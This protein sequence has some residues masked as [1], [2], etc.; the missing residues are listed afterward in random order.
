MARKRFLI[1]G[2]GAAG[3]AAAER[4]RY[5]DPSASI[6]LYTDDPSP[7][8]YRAAL[9]NFLLGELREEQ[10]WAV[11][12]SFYDELSIQRALVRV[13]KVETDKK[14]L[15]L[16]QGGRPI[17]YDALVLACGARARPPT[18]DGSMLPGVMVM[19]TLSDVHRVFDLIKL[20]GLRSAVICGGGPLA[21][22]WAHGLTHRGIKV[23]MVVRDRKFLP[24]A[25]DNVSSDL[26]LARLRQGGVEV[27]MGDEVVQAVPGPQGRV[28]GV[29]LKSG[30]RVGCELVGVAFGVICNSE[31]LQGSPIALSKQGGIV[32]D[33]R[34]SAEQRDAIA[35]IA[36][37]GAGGPMAA[38]SGLVGKFLGVEAAPIDFKRNG[39]SWSVT[40]S[41][42]IRLAG[43]G[44]TG[45]NPDAAPM[46]LTNTG[47]PAA[48]TF[49]LAR[50]M[51]SRVA[52]LGVS[53]SDST[54]RN[55]A[56]YAPFSWANA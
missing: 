7:G 8:Y 16:A 39:N 37:G 31:F 11:P 28:A 51:D 10:V 15:W 9:T 40:A 50:A 47:H 44:A 49:S 19:R 55:N 34:A 4:I 20:K 26:L 5:A 6:G 54:G 45:L 23:M 41:N 18:F 2:D 17:H 35:G 43:H 1:I 42:K 52:V 38:L 29:I 25:I 46:Q 27:R 48:D 56:Q 30:E 32:V 22:E 53:W 21:L 13:A 3:L 14:L 12:P 24:G 36:S 33:E